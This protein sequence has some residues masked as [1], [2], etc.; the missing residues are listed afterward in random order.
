[1]SDVFYVLDCEGLSRA[2]LGNPEMKARLKD[3][4]RSGLR[5]VTSSMTLIEAYRRD[6]QRGTSRWLVPLCCATPYCGRASP[7]CGRASPGRT[8]AATAPPPR[9]RGR[10][11]VE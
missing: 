11:P 7:Y 3:A 5:A 1:M 8:A 10:S 4:H 2:A 6:A 9:R